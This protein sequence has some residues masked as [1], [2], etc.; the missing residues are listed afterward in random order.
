MP[1]T[2]TIADIIF[3]WCVENDLFDETSRDRFDSTVGVLISRGAS[4]RDIAVT[5]RN[6]GAITG[7]TF[8]EIENELLLVV[9]DEDEEDENAESETDNTKPA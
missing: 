5:I 8:E 9:P 7:K 6:H 4:V 2:L 3:D 1:E